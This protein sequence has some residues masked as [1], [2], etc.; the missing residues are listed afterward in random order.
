MQR[1]QRAIVVDDMIFCRDI[2]TE[3]LEDRDY[4]VRSFADVTACPLFSAPMSK[5]PLHEACTD[6]LLLD[7][8]M[9]HMHGVDFL[10]LQQ[11]GN[12]H[13]PINNIAI[14]SASWSR[15]DLDRAFQLGCEIFHKPYSFTVLAS[16]L[17]EREKQ[18]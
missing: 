3:F 11:R 7:N 17:T 12:C 13:I 16:W 15:E 9:P 14:L 5:C 4:L 10:E 18:F 1:K 2:L 8:Q 6:I